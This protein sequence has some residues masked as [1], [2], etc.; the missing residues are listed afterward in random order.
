MKRSLAGASPATGFTFSEPQTCGTIDRPQNRTRPSETTACRGRGQFFLVNKV[1]EANFILRAYLLTLLKHTSDKFINEPVILRPYDEVTRACRLRDV[2]P[3][4]VCL[5]KITRR[6]DG[7]YITHSWS[8]QLW[9]K[10][11][12][13]AD[14][15]IILTAEVLLHTG[16]TCWPR[17]LL[18]CQKS[19]LYPVTWFSQWPS[20]FN[21]LKPHKERDHHQAAAFTGYR[22]SFLAPYNFVGLPPGY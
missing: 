18:S 13:I 9:M 8:K 4:H 7:R 20:A 6:G 17:P 14:K 12:I 5:Y 22:F 2:T 15:C 11:M 19:V 10:S 16:D 3:Q 21:Y 1:H